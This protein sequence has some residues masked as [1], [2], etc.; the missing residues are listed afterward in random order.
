[1]DCQACGRPLTKYDEY[2]VACKG[3]HV[4]TLPE[5]ADKPHPVLRDAGSGDRPL[6]RLIPEPEPGLPAWAPGAVVGA[7]ALV[8][9]IVSL[10]V[11]VL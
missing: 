5:H 11:S 1:M 9:S 3:G 4:W 7:V 2:R 10:L 6:V 8:V